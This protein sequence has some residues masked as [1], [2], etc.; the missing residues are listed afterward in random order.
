MKQKARLIMQA[1]SVCGLLLAVISTLIG[2]HN[3]RIVIAERQLKVADLQRRIDKLKMNG[4]FTE[5]GKQLDQELSEIS[6]DPPESNKLLPLLYACLALNAA[7]M[8]HTAKKTK[9]TE[10]QNGH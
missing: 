6:I 7:A 4:S 10:H 8:W 9:G 3:E 5:E 2:D 1:V